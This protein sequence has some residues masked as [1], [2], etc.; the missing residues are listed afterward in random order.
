MPDKDI[1]EASLEYHR[2]H[3]PGKISLAP[4]KQLTNQRDL[5]M[6]YTPGV[7]AAC[8]EIVRDPAEAANLTAKGN[9]VAVV[10]NGTA[11]LGLGPIGP[12]AAK[13]VMEGK[14]VLFK[15]FAGLDCF[16]I[17]IN[18]RDPDK[19]VDIICALEPTFGAINLEDIK[20]P[21]CFYI[22]RRCRER[23][24]IPVFHDDQHG[25]AIIVGAAVVNGLRVVGKEPKDVKLVCSGAGAAALACLDLLCD[26]GIRRENIFVSDIEGVVY[27]GRV[28]L[29]DEHKA[30]YAQKTDARTLA[31]VLPGADIFLGLSAG[32]VLKPEWLAGMAK[33]PL[34][35]AL[36]N[37]EPEIMPDLAKAARPDAVI[38]TGRSDFPNQVNNVLCFPFIFR[39]ALDVGATAINRQ[40][41]LACVRAIADL[42]MAEQ[43]DV[44]A[45][46]YQIENMRFGPEYLIPKPFDPR[47]ILVIAPA[48]ARAAMESGVATRPIADFE[49]YKQKLLN[50]VYH[51]GLLMKP[52]FQAAKVAPKRIVYAEGEDERV[53]RAV[54]IVVDEGL[55]RPI[56]VGR[57]AVIERRIERFGLRIAPGKDFEMI[58]PEWDERYRDYWSEYYRLTQRKGVSEAYAQIEMRRRLTLIGAMAIHRGDADGMLCGTFGTHELHLQYID[59]VLGLRR[60]V[61]NYAAMNAVVLPTRTVFIADTYVNADPSAEQLAEITLLASEEIRRFG[62][63]PKVAL[64]SHSSFGSSRYPSARKM[65]AALALVNAMDPELE[66]E[67]EMHGDAA[68]SE[69]VRLAAFPN[70]RLKGEAN[71]L[72][73]PTVDAANIAFN[74]LKVAA[75]SNV[76]LGPILLGVAK[77]VHILTPSATVRRIVNMTALTVVDATMQRQP[78]L[79]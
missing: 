2:Q 17:E 70:S 41:E 73:M 47:L 78:S 27:E 75:G 3:P 12:L 72:I 68:L 54:Q 59:Q 11:V 32:K 60:G 31:D 24:K 29:M 58:N 77:A 49:A 21:E 74:L 30:V 62:L 48:V 55:A 50:F 66:V 51:S 57:P 28:K 13:P 36:A 56:L 53:L 25:T 16:D 8:D 42:A 39:G 43:S 63:T 46:A 33:S 61:K 38:A 44:V 45:H 1:R 71:L 6:A 22:E 69:E 34:V 40:M 64:L 4:T 35:L 10:T 23:M 52:I 18:E 15:K 20:A 65:Q 67:G 76:T 7:A 26:L 19:L 9:L 5:A 14:A 79:I 37:P